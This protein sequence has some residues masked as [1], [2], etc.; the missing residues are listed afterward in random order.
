MCWWGVVWTGKAHDS[1][2][3][4]Q[5]LWKPQYPHAAASPIIIIIIIIISLQALL[6]PNPF[7]LCFH[8]NKTISQWNCHT[9]LLLYM[10]EKRHKHTGPQREREEETQKRPPYH[11]AL[12]RAKVFLGWSLSRLL[13]LLLLLLLLHLL[14]LLLHSREW[15]SR[16]QWALQEVYTPR[17]KQRCTGRQVWIAGYNFPLYNLLLLPPSTSFPTFLSSCSFPKQR[18]ST[19]VVVS[20]CADWLWVA[21]ASAATPKR[22]AKRRSYLQHQ[23]FLLLRKAP[24]LCFFSNTPPHPRSEKERKK[25][26]SNLLMG[27]IVQLGETCWTLCNQEESEERMLLQLGHKRLVRHSEIFLQIFFWG[28]DP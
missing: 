5:C 13:L 26:A 19:S 10:K 15:R 4:L 12:W 25:Q 14:L 18:V 6:A 2:I 28:F 8:R 27:A 24:N 11:V 16:A 1:C 7:F 23:I 17:H 3:H 21:N 22:K 20:S 9:C